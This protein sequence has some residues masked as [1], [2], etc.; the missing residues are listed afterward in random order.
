MKILVVGGNTMYASWINAE[1]ELLTSK[2]ENVQL[3]D[4]VIFTG[5]EDVDPNIYGHNRNP[6]S[7]INTKRDQEEI[8]FYHQAKNCGTFMVGICRGAQ[9][10]TALQTRGSLVQ[11]VTGHA[12]GH[13]HEITFSD[14]DRIVATST[15]HQMM[16]PYNCRYEAIAWSTIPLSEQYEFQR[17]NIIPSLPDN[18]EMEIVYY[19][20]SRCLAIQPHPEMMNK[21]SRLVVKL[22]QILTQKLSEIND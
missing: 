4:V 20:S 14:G 19:S 7:S 13:M 3:A 1:I 17:D 12:T 15:H 8:K 16:F 11:H 21:S 9:L 5:G 22:N 6:K 2:L 18:R 10:L